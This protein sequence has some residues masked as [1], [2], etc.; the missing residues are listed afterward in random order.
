MLTAGIAK[1]IRV[2]NHNQKR[3]DETL[4]KNRNR[5][6]AW[7]LAFALALSHAPATSI[8]TVYAATGKVSTQKYTL[9][10]KAG[11]YS[12]PI[13]VVLRAKKGYKVYYA[14]NGKLTTSKV[15]KSKQSK[16]IKIKKTSTLTVYAVKS[17]TKIT[18]KKLKAKSV[19]NAAKTYKYKIAVSSTKST[20]TS[21][22]TNVTK[23]TTTTTTSGGTDNSSGS[24]HSSGSDN[25]SGSDSSSGSD[26]TGNNSGTTTPDTPATQPGLPGGSQP[27]SN[28]SGGNTTNGTVTSG[29]KDSTITDSSTTPLQVTIE[30]PIGGAPIQTSSD[31]FVTTITMAGKTEVL[32]NSPGTYRLSNSSEVLP[33]VDTVIKINP[34][35]KE[36]TKPIIIELDNLYIYNKQLSS[37]FETDLPVISI[38]KNTSEVIFKLKGNNTLVGSST[39]AQSPAPAII[40]AEDNNTK[41]TFTADS[42][43]DSL[44][45]V[46]TLDSN[47]DMG[48]NDPTDGISV[49]GIL[50]VDGG[51]YTI[52]SNGDCLKGTG[53]NGKGG[54]NISGGTFH[55]RSDIGG[56]LKSKNGSINISGG[57]IN[58]TYTK[59]DGIQAKNYKINITGGTLNIDNCYGDGI[60]GEEVNVSGENTALNITTFYEDAGVN[61]YDSSRGTGNY[62]STSTTASSKTELVNVDTGSHKGIKAGTKACTYSYASVADDSSNTAD[63]TYT[64]EASG[65]LTISGG[66]ITIDTTCTGIK[67]NGAGSGMGGGIKQPGSN[68]N[69]SS[70]ST[71]AAN[72]EGQYIIGAPDDGIHSNNTCSIT[73]GTIQIASSDDGITCAS[74]LTIAG[75]AKIE[76]LMAYEGIE[77]GT[78]TVGDNL[79]AD[80]SVTV[81]SNDDGIN[82]SGNSSVNYVYTDETEEKY[83]KTEISSNNNTLTINSGYV[84]V[85]IADDKSHSYT[86]NNSDS[87]TATGTFSADGDGIDCNGSFY[88]NGGTIIVYGA[89]SND[90]TAID[91]DGTYSIASGVTLL[92]AGSNGMVENPTQTGQCTLTYGGSSN[93]FGRSL[94]GFGGNTGFGSSTSSSTITAGTT[95]GILDSYG[96]M[97]ACF[98]APKA[99]SHILYSSPALTVNAN[100]TISTGGTIAGSANS[101]SSYDYR[102]MSYDTTGAATLTTLTAK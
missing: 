7:I 92:A 100:Y 17:S 99:I 21:T 31:P 72:N 75:N 70:G 87:T 10:K 20:S 50:N 6:F 19:K 102:G 45:I 42:N 66:T 18:A 16:T 81:Y 74:A 86:L 62:N 53:K 77:A 68:A 65:G 41:V 12:A 51:T 26:H 89:G 14:L 90:N 9:S 80:P 69:S 85:M 76:I 48:D 56:G 78:I 88:A 2:S 63:T 61:Y 93:G 49:K 36:I 46:D 57:V 40:Y 32:L 4:M 37:N 33:V 43:E 97:V 54:I 35:N 29:T 39:F 71:A 96:A 38:G 91:T 52:L 60:Q 101:A 58:C 47:A 67:Y 5:I 79:G 59:E 84:N 23:I 28:P 95:V 15:I 82:A 83:T 8:T 30:E 73:G 44:T 13:S 98:T 34:D 24:D 22:T 3:K 11:N 64:Q 55:L 1:S 25:S 27:G 94:T